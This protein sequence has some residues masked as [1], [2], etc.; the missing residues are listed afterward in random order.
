MYERFIA[1]LRGMSAI[2]WKRL[3]TGAPRWCVT[4]NAP[5]FSSRLTIRS[6]MAV[7]GGSAL[8]CRVRLRRIQKHGDEALLLLCCKTDDAVLRE[9][10]FR[11][12]ARCIDDEVAHA[13]AGQFGGATNHI[14]RSSRDA[15]LDT[16]G[17]GLV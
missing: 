17:A 3:Y 9:V 2:S 12:L 11:L 4:S 16:L 13:A 1:G 6:P 15:R 7:R 8:Q 10:P 5:R 14:E